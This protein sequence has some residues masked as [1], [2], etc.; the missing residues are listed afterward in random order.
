[1]IGTKGQK[2]YLVNGLK[3]CK[4]SPVD[5]LHMLGFKTSVLRIDEIGLTI[6]HAI[7]RTTVMLRPILIREKSFSQTHFPKFIH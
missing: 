2:A 3:I 1:M 7:C 5:T 6:K 4:H